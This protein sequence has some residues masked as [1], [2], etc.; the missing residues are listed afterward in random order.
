M[1]KYYSTHLTIPIVAIEA[2]SAGQAEAIINEFLDKIAPIMEDVITWH[3][4]DWI[5]TEVVDNE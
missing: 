5:I 4:A 2:N 3:D 1:K